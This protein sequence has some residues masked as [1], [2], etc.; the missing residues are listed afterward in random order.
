MR[1]ILNIQNCSGN[2]CPVFQC[3]QAQIL[4]KQQRSGLIGRIIWDGNGDGGCRLFGVRSSSSAGKRKYSGENEYG[5]QYECKCFFHDSF[6]F[7]YFKLMWYSD[8]VCV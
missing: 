3:D 4:Q 7:L 5:N 1:I 2:A 6:S 8:S